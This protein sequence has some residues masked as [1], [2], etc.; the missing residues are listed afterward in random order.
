V[1][2]RDDKGTTGGR[3]PPCRLPMVNDNQTTA[4]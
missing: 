4:K 3:Q 1:N 2:D